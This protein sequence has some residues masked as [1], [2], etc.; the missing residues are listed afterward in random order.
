MIIKGNSRK[1]KFLSEF[2]MNIGKGNYLKRAGI[3]FIGI[4]VC[5]SIVITLYYSVYFGLLFKNSIIPAK[6]HEVVEG[7]VTQPKALVSQL[8]LFL[9]GLVVKADTVN[10]HIKHV[11]FQRLAYERDVVLNGYQKQAPFTYVRATVEH[12]KRFIPV[13]IRLKGDR[14]VHYSD[15][16]KWSF[17]VKID[18]DMETLFGMKAFSL[19]KPGTRNY[20]Y[21]WIFHEALR[22]EGVISPRYSFI[23]VSLNGKKLGVYALEEHFEKRLLEN[24]NR[25][26]GPIIHFDEGITTDLSVAP[27]K[28]YKEKKWKS[29]DRLPMVNK[30][31]NLLEL[32]RGKKIT[33]D[34]VFDITLTARYF[35][36]LDLL[37]MHHAALWKNIRFYYN[38]ITSKLEPIGYDGHHLAVDPVP[39]I[40]PEVGTG[41]IPKSFVN[42]DTEWLRLFFYDQLTFDSNFFSEYIRTLERI[43]QT[44]YLDL[45]FD[46]IKRELRR[47]LA[48][49]HRDF[50]LLKDH[51]LFFGPELFVFEKKDFYERQEYIRDILHGSGDLIH[52]FKQDHLSEKNLLVLD[53]RNIS[54]FPVK[55][56]SS[57]E[58]RHGNTSISLGISDPSRK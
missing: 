12:N 27:I 8:A 25:R 42:V 3:I 13:K 32:F 26:E 44:G 7:A 1:K 19:Q 53:I 33:L 50:P 46:N 52:A 37:G 57:S 24:N 34:E 35:A 51:L 18:S 47:N 40:M 48:I 43:G 45:L 58:R 20:I 4:F 49:L 6:I 41:P 56:D 39:L 14:S 16:E 36:V 11:N 5:S 17:R 28:V 10:I 23:N 54:M 15:K 55:I 22:R 9:K 30:A 29:S 31:I 38:P 2:L 21:E